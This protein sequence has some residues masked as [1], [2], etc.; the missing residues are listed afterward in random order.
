MNPVLVEGMLGLGDN[1]YQIPIIRRLAQV[2]SVYLRTPWP[3]LYKDIGSVS[4]VQMETRL[5]T[6]TKNILKN[7]QTYATLPAVYDRMRLSYV[8]Y[9]KKGV[10]FYK[11]L[12]AAAGLLNFK[13]YLNLRSACKERKNYAVI[14]PAT[15]R[16]E[17]KAPSRNPRPEY[18]QNA[19]N[20]LAERGIETIV[21]AD[22]DPP[23]EIY[24]GPRPSASRYYEF[25]ELGVE[26]VLDLV[27]QAKI[28]VGPVGFIAPM[29]IALGTPAVI[30]H[31]GVGG[32]SSPQ[33]INAPG[34]G[35][36]THVLP[37]SYCYC[38]N[39]SHNCNK[40]MDTQLIKKA[41]DS[42]L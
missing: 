31:G 36:L 3:Q 38:Q 5:R 13:Y 34:E 1:I 27:H 20:R 16:Q 22:I 12:S 29:C 25:G 6:Q 39:H 17:W 41:I 37:K 28:V 30:L 40:E 15:L 35:E 33:M 2:R 21:V 11:G 14:R 24:D 19:I 42:I 4:F 8:S 10:A 18:I 9:Q 32:Y 23:H 7:H 26:Q